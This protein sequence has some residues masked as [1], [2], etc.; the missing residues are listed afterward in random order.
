VL[1]RGA[2]P[3]NLTML[4]NQVTVLAKTFER[5]DILKRLVDSI[6]R[7]YPE[8]LVIVVDDSRDPLKLEG[9][10]T[11][12]LPYNSGLSAGRNAGLAQVKTP[13]V[14]L[15]DD[16]YI[17]YRHTN[18][19]SVLDSLDRNPDID[20]L[21]GGRV[22][23]PFFNIVNYRE[24]YLYPSS[25]VPKHPAGFWVGGFEVF[26]KVANFFIARTDRL[27]LIGWDP[28]LKLIEHADF[29]TRAKGV[30]TT[31]YDPSFKVL[32][33]QNSFDRNYMRHRNNYGAYRVLLR[34]K[35]EKE[36]KRNQ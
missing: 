19:G 17:F 32:H 24:A 34:K 29:F 35:Y 21:G 6:R 22:D 25:E 2:G 11:I 9:V 12:I 20:I 7:F 23:L 33:A 30:L 4:E 8:L 26:N 28:A 31:V 16:D 27:K 18:I 36:V 13:Y 14:L 15:L 10:E 5:P 1:D 3:M